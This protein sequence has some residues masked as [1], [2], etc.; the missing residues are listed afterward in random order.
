MERL[1]GQTKVLNACDCGVCVGNSQSVLALPEVV[2]GVCNVL[3]VTALSPLNGEVRT[4][5]GYTHSM[6]G[7]S[8]FSSI[9]GSAPPCTSFLVILV[10]LWIKSLKTL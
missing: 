10:I 8:T 5:T 7:E 6:G 3:Q 1:G 9:S 2:T 4:P